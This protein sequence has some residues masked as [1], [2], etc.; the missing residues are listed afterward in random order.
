MRLCPAAAR[1]AY[2]PY[3]LLCFAQALELYKQIL[4]GEDPD[5]IFHLYAAGCLYY[6]GVYD[7][8]E[9]AANEVAATVDCLRWL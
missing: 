9:A 3:P 5:P 6:M 7:E 8:A 4:A 2:S 1:I